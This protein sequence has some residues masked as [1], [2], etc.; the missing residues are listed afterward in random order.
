MEIQKSTKHL[1]FLMILL[2][3]KQFKKNITEE[4]LH[5]FL[6]FLC[7][8]GLKN[9]GLM[10]GTGSGCFQSSQDVVI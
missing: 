7:N 9:M 6:D 4:G 1:I 3:Q 10:P 5:P 8:F 2:L